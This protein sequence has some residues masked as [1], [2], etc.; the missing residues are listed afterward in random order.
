MERMQSLDDSERKVVLGSVLADELKVILE[1]VKDVPAIKQELHRVKATVD[2]TH[3]KL[4]L[5]EHVVKEHE[6][7]LKALK[8]KVA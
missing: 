5:F 1:Y 6:T 3:E 8:Q 7:D 4:T 2:D